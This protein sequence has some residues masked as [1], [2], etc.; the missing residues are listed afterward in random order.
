MKSTEDIYTEQG[1]Q[2]ELIGPKQKKISETK[3]TQTDA[4][5]SQ[6]SSF[7]GPIWSYLVGD[8]EE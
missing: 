7:F 8:R 4:T 3:C 6:I 2:I 1:C 5:K